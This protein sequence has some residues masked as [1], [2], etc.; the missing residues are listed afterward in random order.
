M[1]A[2]GSNDSG[3]YAQAMTAF[4]AAAGARQQSA[5]QEKQ[6]AQE[7][8]K[9]ASDAITQYTDPIGNELIKQGVGKVGGY[10]NAAK[11]KVGQVVGNYAEK[12]TSKL[13]SSLTG[14][15][16]RVATATESVLGG[17][18]GAAGAVEGAAAAEG[19]LNPIADIAAIGL[20]LASIFEGHKK[21]P[22][23]P[24]PPPQ[25]PAVNLSSVGGVIG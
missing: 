9:S 4:A 7:E 12:I 20:G 11:S 18:E 14:A 13:A 25:P 21:P 1:D 8:A 17:V 5:N 23:P 6:E 15:P 3:K 16:A 10:V 2:M 22:P 19:G 24:P